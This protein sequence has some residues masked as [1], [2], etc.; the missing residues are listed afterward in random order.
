[1]AKTRSDR[2]HC[3]FQDEPGRRCLCLRPLSTV[4]GWDELRGIRM[5]DE[6]RSADCPHRQWSRERRDDVLMARSVWLERCPG[7]GHRHDSL[8]QTLQCQADTLMGPMLSEMPEPSSDG[9]ADPLLPDRFPTFIKER[10]WGKVRAA[11]LERDRHCCREC[12]RDLLRY[13]AWYTE[14]HHVMPVI[15]GGSDHPANLITL[16]TECHGAHTDAMGADRAP[17]GKPGNSARSNPRGRVR[18]LSLHDIRND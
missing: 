3:Q 10:A 9:S 14:V 7:C 2:T 11:V 6:A 15:S 12:G 16:C 1:M 18:Q 17:D 8:R 5:C 4:S 13:P